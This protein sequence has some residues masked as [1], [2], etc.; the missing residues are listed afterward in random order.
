MTTH[1]QRGMD[2]GV[3][4][5]AAVA[6]RIADFLVKTEIERVQLFRLHLRTTVNRV[7]PLLLELAAIEGISLSEAVTLIHPPQDWPWRP[8]MDHSPSVIRRSQHRKVWLGDVGR[9]EVTRFRR[10][11]ANP[12]V[13]VREADHP[14][15]RFGIRP[16]GATLGF[17]AALGPALLSVF[18]ATA[19]IKLPEALPETLMMALPGRPLCQVVDHPIFAGA[20]YGI[21]N[22]MLDPADGRPVLN[23]RT[24]LVSFALP[25]LGTFQD[26]EG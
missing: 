17:T 1:G 2:C 20:R 4:P 22:A 10:A 19:V 6:F 8:L 12:G 18:G 24:P 26:L 14:R 13:V 16:V 11:F 25:I 5:E 21:R 9:P 3:S 7:S 23:F 15:G